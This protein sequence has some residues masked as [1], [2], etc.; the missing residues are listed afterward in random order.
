[1]SPAVSTLAEKKAD[2]EARIREAALHLFAELGYHGTTMPLIA[3]R[4]GVGAGTLYRYF[5]SKEAMV[6]EVFR[7][8]KR[9][10]EDVAIRRLDF[11]LDPPDAFAAFWDGLVRF[12]REFPAEFA[13]LE[14]HDHV[15]YLDA[16]SR[17]LELRVLD[18]IF[19]AICSYIASG[20]LRKM[21]PETL[22]ALIWGAFVG[23]VKYD[24]LGHFSLSEGHWIAARDA[25]WA[26]C[27]A[28]PAPR[29]NRKKEER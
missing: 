2:K 26:A 10:L 23:L 22:M 29:R 24:H 7:A 9:R 3:E 19:E 17:E 16:E 20:V 15:P 8:A 25:C 21:P 5:P 18:P 28:P 14:L 11:S 6:N 13:F 4:A 12:A 1:M 27:V